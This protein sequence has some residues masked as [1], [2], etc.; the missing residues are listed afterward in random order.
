MCR[1]PAARASDISA[2]YQGDGWSTHA[3]YSY[4]DADYEFTGTLASPNNPHADANGNVTVT[5][6][7]HMPVDPAN[8]FRAGG[9]GDILSGLSGGRRPGLH[10]QPIL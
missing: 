10:R 2:Q 5:P 8:Q 9:D 3:S 4:L 7:R 1:S 6:G